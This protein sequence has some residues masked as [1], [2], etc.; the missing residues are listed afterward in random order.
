MHIYAYIYIYSAMPSHPDPRGCRPSSK[1][2]SR[3]HHKLAL[4]NNTLRCSVSAYHVYRSTCLAV[5]PSVR[6]C[7]CCAPICEQRKVTRSPRSN[8]RIG[9]WPRMRVSN[10]A[11]MIGRY[12][13]ISILIPD[14]PSVCL[15][16]CPTVRLYE[17]SY[18]SHTNKCSRLRR[19]TIRANWDTHLFDGN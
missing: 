17:Y 11:L 12:I 18:P 7:C 8:R 14:C 9:P 2:C 3:R 13:Q 15:S 10:P 6:C 5:C 16:V 4:Y 1:R 19:P